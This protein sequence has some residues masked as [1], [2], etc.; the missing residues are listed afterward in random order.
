MEG[1]LSLSMAQQTDCYHLIAIY[2]VYRSIHLQTA[3][4]ADSAASSPPP[5]LGPLLL[6]PLNA[7]SLDFVT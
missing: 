5:C 2:G 4:G 3:L 1:R 6:V 7:L